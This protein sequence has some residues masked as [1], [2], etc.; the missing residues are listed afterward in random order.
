[1]IELFSFLNLNASIMIVYYLNTLT[2]PSK[3]IKIII[4][5]NDPDK[6]LSVVNFYIIIYIRLSIYP[7]PI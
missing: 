7:D 3:S 2:S 5:R 1:M 6:Q 4:L